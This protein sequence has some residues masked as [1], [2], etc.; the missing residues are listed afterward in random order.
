M[1]LSTIDAGTFKCDGGAIFGSVPKILWS[2]QV[3]VDEHNLLKTALRCLLI[4][5]N[6]RKILI[7]TGTGTK[8]PEKFNANNGVENP[9]NLLK[10]LQAIGVEANEITDVLL[11][12][13]H[14]DHSGGCT[15]YDAN[16]ILQL[17]F[18]NAMYHCSTKQWENSHA[19]NIRENDAY[20]LEDLDLIKTKNRLNL[21]DQEGF[22]FENI[23][24]RIFDGHTPG[25]IIPI[26]HY[27]NK[28]IVYASDFTPLAANIRLKW[29]AA[30]DLFPVTT[31]ENKASFLK[32]IYEENMILYFE[33]DLETECCTVKWDEKKGPMADIKGSLQDFI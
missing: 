9:E 7:E 29:V 11:T 32:E 1:K 8:H 6:D 5:T 23:E 13:L 16:N 19:P 17:T 12:H 21:I 24:L 4:E 28:K 3:T 27:R 31:M 20:F 22:L 30:Y 2:K 15:Y 10:S 18:P 33:H 14:W 25:Q 26:I